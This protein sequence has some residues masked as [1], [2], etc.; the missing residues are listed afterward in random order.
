MKNTVIT[1]AVVLAMGFLSP[2]VQAQGTLCVSNLGQTPTSSAAIG[3]NSW[4]AQQFVVSS[5]YTLNSVELLMNSASGTPADFSISIYSSLNPVDNLSSLNGSTSP[6]AGSVYTYT[7][8]NILLSRG[9]YYLVVTAGTSV[10]EGAYN[11]SAVNNVGD[12]IGNGMGITDTYYDS[13]DGSNWTEVIRGDVFQMAIYA[14]P[15]PE[16]AALSLLF[17]GGGALIYVRRNCRGK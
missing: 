1:F 13:T 8:S 2:L 4:I 6:S 9:A 14:T 17:L 12:T 10:S 3:S 7:A 16:P 15:T 11:W 5:N